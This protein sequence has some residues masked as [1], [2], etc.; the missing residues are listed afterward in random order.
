MNF[1]DAWKLT[2]WFLLNSDDV[3]LHP[4]LVLPNTQFYSVHRTPEAVKNF[5]LNRDQL[6]I[7]KLWALAVPY[8]IGSPIPIPTSNLNL[9]NYTRLLVAL[10]IVCHF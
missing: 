9:W 2:I 8:L 7:D 5:A 3:S 4:L 10:N 1:R 6:F